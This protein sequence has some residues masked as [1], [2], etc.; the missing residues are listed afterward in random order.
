M[1]AVTLQCE[2]KY[3]DGLKKKIDV[4]TE[5]NLTSMM[6]GIKKLNAEVSQLLTELVA[7]EKLFSGGDCDDDEKEEDSDEDEETE[8]PKTSSR[9]P[10]PPEPPAKR[11]RTL[12]T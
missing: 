12:K 1:A 5:N 3:R 11:S 9:V 7:R 4:N 10:E 8:K 6:A 2:L